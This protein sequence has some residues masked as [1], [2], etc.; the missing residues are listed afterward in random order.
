MLGL[1]A[2]VKVDAVVTTNDEGTLDSLRQ[3]YREKVAAEVKAELTLGREKPIIEVES[4]PI[5]R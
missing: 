5:E 4:E 1:D 2:P 3:A